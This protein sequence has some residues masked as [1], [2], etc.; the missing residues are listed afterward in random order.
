MLAYLKGQYSVRERFKRGGIG[1][2]KVIYE[3][4]IAVFDK[5]LR[6]L[7]TETAFASF[8]LQKNGLTVRMNINQ[9]LSCIGIESSE[10]E[11]IQ[12][13]AYPVEVNQRVFL[14][15]KKRTIYHGD[16]EIRLFTQT[17]KFTVRELEF[18]DILNYFTN[19]DLNEKF[20]YSVSLDATE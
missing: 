2:S 3:S 4:G 11:A 15:R 5:L 7:A 9:R 10:I 12:L 8:E 16:L 19:A 13:T 18:K 1:S 6:G 17:L 14:R 20:Q